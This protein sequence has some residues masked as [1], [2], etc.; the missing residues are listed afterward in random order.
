[1]RVN[2]RPRGYNGTQ[3]AFADFNRGKIDRG[4][5]AP[6]I[7]SDLHRSSIIQPFSF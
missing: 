4:A 3:S 2:S 5:V 6:R 7:R 1:M